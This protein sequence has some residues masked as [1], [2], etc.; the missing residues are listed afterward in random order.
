M[1]PGQ[2]G[3][4]L[5]QCKAQASEER[6]QEGL[7]GLASSWEIPCDVQGALDNMEGAVRRATGSRQMGGAQEK[8][9]GLVP[10][11][12]NQAKGTSRGWVEPVLAFPCG[13]VVRF[14]MASSI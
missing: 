3:A 9:R 4:L 12:A 1:V 11:A 6:T 14:Q 5:A 10:S 2:N 8:T 7:A 13:R